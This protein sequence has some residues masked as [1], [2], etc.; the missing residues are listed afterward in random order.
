MTNIEA[1]SSEASIVYNKYKS[2]NQLSNDFVFYIPYYLNMPTSNAKLPTMGNPNN[3]LSS[4]TVDGTSVSKFS[5]NTT[6]YNVE[7][8][9]DKKSINVK[10]VAVAYKTSYVSVAGKAKTLKEQTNTI[11]LSGDITK[12][13][14]VVT[15]ANGSTKTYTINITK[16]GSSNTTPTTP[17]P[18]VNNDNSVNVTNLINKSSF[19]ES[20]GYIRGITLGMTTDTFTNSIK[21]LDSS[22]TVSITNRSNK[23]KTGVLVTGDTL[24]IT[25]CNSKKTMTA[26]VYGDNN[27]DGKISIKDL[28]LVQRSILG[29]TKLTGAYMEA[30]D[31]N[32]DGK[33]NI[34]DLLI[35]QKNILG[36]MNISQI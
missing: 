21:K 17:A 2:N 12:V 15:A 28:L 14:I 10:G 6:T 19:K 18:V 24:T 11:N 13:N 30:S 20:N 1:P 32:K 33:I 26:V 31:V 36:Y 35:I 25:T 27:G 4:L 23:A 7:V 9:N 29:Y 34:K 5:G 8:A 22:A 16:K 3:W